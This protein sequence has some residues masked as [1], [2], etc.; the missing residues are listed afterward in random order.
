MMAAPLAAVHAI[1]TCSASNKNSPPS[2]RQQQQTT[3]TTATRGSPAALPSLLR[4]TAAAAATA[5]LALA[6]PDALAAGGEFGILEGRS[7]AL[8]HPLVMG[9]LFAYTLWAGYLGWQWRRVRTIQDEINELKKQLKPAAAAATPAA[10]AAGEEEADQGI[11]P[12]PAFQRR[13]HPAR[14]GGHRVRRR[15][16]QHVVPHRQALPGAAPLRRRRHH[17]ALGRRGG[18]GPGD[19]EGERDG[20]EPAHRAQRHQRP[21][22]HLADPHRPRDRRQG[23]RVHHMAMNKQHNTTQCSAAIPFSS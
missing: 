3:T 4:T 10:V 14:A 19:A 6:P 22:L 9:G 8:L 21:P 5:A 18:A 2:A 15:R 16:A 13:L 20:A 11:V 7:V 1:I 17:R 23:L 12:G